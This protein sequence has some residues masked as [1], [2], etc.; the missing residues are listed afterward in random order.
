MTTFRREAVKQVQEDDA[1]YVSGLDES[2]GSIIKNRA[3][4]KYEDFRSHV[5]QQQTM[6]SLGMNSILDLSYAFE[7]GQSTLFSQ[8]Q[9]HEL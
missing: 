8:K 9:W 2:V 4:E 5:I 6:I 3:L 7:E 1:V